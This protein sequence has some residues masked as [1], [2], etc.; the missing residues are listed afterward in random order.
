MNYYYVTETDEDTVKLLSVRL[1]K[2]GITVNKNDLQ[3]FSKSNVVYGYN[4]LTKEI[5]PKTLDDVANIINSKLNLVSDVVEIVGVEFIGA[6]KSKYIESQI[7]LRGEEQRTLTSNV[8][9]NINVIDNNTVQIRL[10]IIDIVRD[11]CST[12]CIDYEKIF[13]DC[14]NMV[15]NLNWNEKAIN[16]EILFDFPLS[17]EVTAISANK[18]YYSD[19]TYKITKIE[20]SEKY[21]MSD[22]CICEHL[23]SFET[24]VVN[25]TEDGYPIC[26]RDDEV[27]IITEDTELDLSRYNA[28]KLEYIL[29]MFS[30]FRGKIKYP[31]FKNIDNTESI[32]SERHLTQEDLNE[33]Y[34]NILLK[35]RR[36]S[37]SICN[38]RVGRISLETFYK[39]TP[40][41]SNCSIDE[42]VV[43]D[44]VNINELLK[45]VSDDFYKVAGVFLYAI[46]INRGTGDAGAVTIPLSPN[47]TG[48]KLTQHGYKLNVNER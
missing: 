17:E 28:E 38:C 39:I 24:L 22:V 2:Q 15:S 13:K 41:M 8:S 6:F 19:Y 48:L 11:T 32:I 47:F 40:Y 46:T 37:D 3:E 44:R 21:D 10:Y 31:K 18:V 36:K 35:T 43:D 25:K 34:D 5:T 9:Y 42:V 33:F 16:L 14:F 12:L 29:S 26:I 30:G 45:G 1:N 27:C 23:F 4:R 20:F 7:A